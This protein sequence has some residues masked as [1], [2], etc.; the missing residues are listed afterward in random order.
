MIPGPPGGV[1]IAPAAVAFV[2]ALP[3][4]PVFVRAFK[5]HSNSVRGAA[6]LPGGLSALTAGVDGTLRIRDIRSGWELYQFG[7]EGH[8]PNSL[9]LLPEGG[10]LSSGEEGSIVLWNLAG[11][12]ELRRYKG[13]DGAVIT[14]VPTADGTQF[15]T[16]GVDR[17]V[18]LWDISSGKEVRRFKVTKV[19]SWLL[20]SRRKATGC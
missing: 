14:I 8:R 20:P 18:R 15:I 12:R 16:A 2:P 3:K 7:A 1:G 6:F 19:T 13:H 9:A 4:S 11:I 17:T 10:A 5:G